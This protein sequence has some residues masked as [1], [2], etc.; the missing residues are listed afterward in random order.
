[1]LSHQLATRDTAAQVL[2]IYSRIRQPL[3]KEA[4]RRSR[5]NGEH[6]ALRRLGPDASPLRL[7]E[8]RKDIQENFEW[9]SEADAKQDMRRAMELL[10]AELTA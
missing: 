10:M 5:V 4:W 8:I 6:F 3:A 7:Q 1:L 2:G 9:V